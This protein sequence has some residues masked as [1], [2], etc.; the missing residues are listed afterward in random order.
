MVDHIYGRIN[1]L[2]NVD[3]PNL[4]I[5][6]QNLY[7]AYLKKDIAA[8]IHN[9]NDKKV[10]YFTKFRDQLLNGINYYKELLPELFLSTKN[11]S[12][13]IIN[14]LLQAEHELDTL[15]FDVVI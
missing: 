10:K 4:F 6:E 13:A 5:N 15:F 7:I 3:R 1:L 8:N 9:I 11:S 12:K 14:Q 2:E